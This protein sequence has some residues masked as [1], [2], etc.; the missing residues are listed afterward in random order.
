NDGRAEEAMASLPDRIDAFERTA[1]VEAVVAAR[2]DIGRAIESLG[3]PR[4]TFYYKVNK[5]GIDLRLLRGR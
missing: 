2:G 5:H 3:V 4:K 1:I